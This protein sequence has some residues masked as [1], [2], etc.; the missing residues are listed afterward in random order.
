[1]RQTKQPLWN[2][3]LTHASI[4][5]L[6]IPVALF[7]GKLIA[8]GRL[9]IL[10]I[11]IFLA[12]I[13][14]T[15][16]CLRSKYWLAVVFALT[17]N[18]PVLPLGDRALYLAEVLIPIAFVVHI[19]NALIRKTAIFNKNGI[20]IWAYFFIVVAAFLSNPVG[21]AAIGSESFGARFYYKV[22][23]GLCS[24]LIIF[25]QKV[26]HNDCKIV[27]RFLIFGSFV[28]FFNMVLPYL[29]NRVIVTPF[30]YYTW[31][32]AMSV[33][34]SMLIMWLVSR[35]K[36][37]TVLS[38]IRKQ[39]WLYLTCMFFI[40]ISG[41][42]AAFA[43]AALAPVIMAAVSRKY[44][45][46]V[47]IMLLGVLAL[48]VLIAGQGR[49]YELPKQAQRTLIFLPGDWDR[50]VIGY[51]NTSFRTEMRKIAWSHV[52]RNPLQGRWGFHMTEYD[53]YRIK[54]LPEAQNM[55]VAQLSAGIAW[56]STWLG[57]MADLGIPAAVMW[58]GFLI[59][60]LLLARYGFKIVLRDT[61]SYTLLGMFFLSL[62][63]H[64]IT[65]Y[66][67]G[68]SSGPPYQFW[69]FY[70]LIVA[71]ANSSKQN[72]EQTIDTNE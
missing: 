30:D 4:F 55:T 49:L 65:S 36:I 1:M 28:T 64:I 33:P 38:P 41:K 63:F 52:L 25:N 50:H 39:A 34:T 62:I 69:W 11:I 21:F 27:I 31:H 40:L 66:T 71:L 5:A 46:V 2:N 58:A 22:L 15:L 44:V 43:T 29:T 9:L 56:H 24:Y 48:S 26:T 57:M 17:V 14:Y 18:L 53:F 8:S 72:E 32:Q 45:Y 16:M 19:L 42:R 7:I 70:G 23:L 59:Q 37:E 67:S 61:H 68:D 6:S 10:A 51:R 47:S 20:F 13:S 35:F 54:L 60:A 3:K 12:L